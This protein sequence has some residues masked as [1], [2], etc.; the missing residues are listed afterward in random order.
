VDGQALEAPLGAQD[1]AEAVAR[2]LRIRVVPEMV[3][4]GGEQRTV[5]SGI[6]K[7]YAPEQM[8]GRQVLLIA[9]LEPRKMRFGVSEGM[10]LCASGDGDPVF[11]L[12]PDAGA[13]PGMKVS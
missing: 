7:S 12:G 6:R 1:I 3:D 5:F 8:V 13:L 4:L 9:N 10:V 11:L 2:Q